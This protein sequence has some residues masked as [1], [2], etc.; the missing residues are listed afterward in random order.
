MY[1]VLI[2]VMILLL[3][4]VLK[5]HVIFSVTLVVCLAHARMENHLRPSSDEIRYLQIVISNNN[6]VNSPH[7]RHQVV[8]LCTQCRLHNI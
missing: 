3:F 4:L 5:I 2:I 7:V 8:M 6:V 1:Y